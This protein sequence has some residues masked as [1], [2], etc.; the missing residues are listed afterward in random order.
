[1]SALTENGYPREAS[2]PGGDT[3]YYVR[4]GSLPVFRGAL[5][6]HRIGV[7]NAEVIDG[8]N[9]RS[10]LLVIGV[11]CNYV[12]STTVA[13][14]SQD[15][16][17]AADA[18][19]R[20][21]TV[22]VEADGWIHRNFDL[23]TGVNALSAQ[24]IGSIVYAFDSNTLYKTD[25]GGTLSPAGVLSCFDTANSLATIDWRTPSIGAILNAASIGGGGTAETPRA[26][27]TT[28]AACTASGGALTANAVGAFGT[29]DGVATL[30]QGDTVFI[31][32]GTTNLPS[33]ADAGPYEIGTLGTASV[34]NV[35]RRP[36]WWSH[37]APV[38]QSARVRIG[39]EGTLYAG[40]EW[41]SFIATGRII[42]TDAPLMYPDQVTQA[43]TLVA[44]TATIA[45]VPVRLAAKTSVNVTRTTPNTSTLTVGG[46]GPSTLT[47]GALGTASVVIQ[48]KVAAGT[49]N[50]A[51]VST[52]NV[53]IVNF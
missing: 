36:S 27:V 50:N 42:G 24:D 46:Y 16:T 37:G 5:V 35:L 15:T 8:A 47:A 14:W 45:T 6:A 12:P 29:Q 1:M 21:L 52:L 43:V 48:A 51:D 49:I 3:T 17:I 39:G 26:V 32:E 7:K 53:A 38:K 20:P 2:K 23:G 9:P 30:A 22:D 19:D 4:Y 28:L 31:P 11:A 13:Q 44:G 33:A 41:Q 10:D 34:I 25:N 40:T 18:D